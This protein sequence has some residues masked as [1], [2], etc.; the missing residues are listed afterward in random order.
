MPIIVKDIKVNIIIKFVGS[1]RN[2]I[3]HGNSA[4]NI[5]IFCSRNIGI[6]FVRELIFSGLWSGSRSEQFIFLNMF[7][8]DVLHLRLSDVWSYN[9]LRVSF[10]IPEVGSDMTKKLYRNIASDF[11]GISTTE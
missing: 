11:R 2:S 3:Y 5:E 4:G 7:Y 1:I 9:M 8:K 6:F 10:F